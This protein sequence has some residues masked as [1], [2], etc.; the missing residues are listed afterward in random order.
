MASNV[1]SPELKRMIN[2]ARQAEANAAV[3]EARATA[4]H[5]D[6]ERHEI[7]VE[8]T[9]GSR[10]SIPTNQIQG[11]EGAPRNTLAEVEVSPSGAS[12]HWETL[13]VDLSVSALVAGVF[14]TRAWMAELGRRGGQVTSEAKA[15][16][17][18]ENGRK[19]GRPRNITPSPK[20]G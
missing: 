1:L 10:L 15:K 6:P 2:R 20:G 19:G 8:F 14:G 7:V 13:D 16:A 12:L 3:T 11:L 4:A 17:A 9:N 5:Y 18:R